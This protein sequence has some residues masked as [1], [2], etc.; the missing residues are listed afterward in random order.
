MP[1]EL[2]DDGD[3]RS[4]NGL[5]T[6][7]ARIATDLNVYTGIDYAEIIQHLNDYWK[8]DQVRAWAAR[9]CDGGGWMAVGVGGRGGLGGYSGSR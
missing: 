9:A 1:A 3:R 4:A 2:M 8:I 6:D 7:F 5:Y